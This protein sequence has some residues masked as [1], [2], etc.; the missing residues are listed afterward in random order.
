MG[1][2]S[3]PMFAIS[4]SAGAASVGVG[5]VTTPVL[6]A[7]PART[8]IVTSATPREMEGSGKP[9]RTGTS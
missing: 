3:P 1:G 9:E 6:I 2:W 4:G 7:T 8:L 5:I